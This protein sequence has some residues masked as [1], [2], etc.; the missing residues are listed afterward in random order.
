MMVKNK[1]LKQKDGVFS[2]NDNNAMILEQNM[3]KPLPF[4]PNY[5]EQSDFNF[6][7]TNSNSNSTNPATCLGI[8]SFL[9]KLTNE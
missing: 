5:A 9:G 2:S 4:T 3:S 1:Y 8:G 7:D 6:Y